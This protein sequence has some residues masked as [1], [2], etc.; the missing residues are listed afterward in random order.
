MAVGVGVDEP[1]MDEALR[2][3]DFARTLGRGAAGGAE[4][5]DRVVLNQDVGRL[6][7]PGP[8]VEDQPAALRAE[9]IVGLTD[10]PTPEFLI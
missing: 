4:L 3:R 8:N 5:A 9:A 10:N 7:G 2:G 6:G 1:G